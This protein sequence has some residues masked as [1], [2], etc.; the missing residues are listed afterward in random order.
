[1]GQPTL[2]PQSVR[3]EWLFE[4]VNRLQPF[5]ASPSDAAPLTADSVF[6]AFPPE[7]EFEHEIKRHLLARLKA[8]ES[9][10][11]VGHA[12]HLFEP[13]V[14]ASN[15]RAPESAGAD[16]AVQGAQLLLE[17]D[18]ARHWTVETL[19]RRVGCNRTDLEVG[20]WRRTSQS[21]HRYLSMRRVDAAK[22]LLRTT[23][24]R[25][26]EVAKA[27]GYR[28]KVSLYAH[29]RRAVCLTPDEY[30]RRWTPVAPNDHLR[31]LLARLSSD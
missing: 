14:N 20:F 16:S 8:E 2:A 27:V 9:V 15:E 31:R 10:H 24:W 23:A 12:A 13:H 7:S 1:M 26:E 30:R 18:F 29:F 5:V 11:A 22:T 4:V 19:A 28:S 6:E 25:V 21:V 17:R 3:P